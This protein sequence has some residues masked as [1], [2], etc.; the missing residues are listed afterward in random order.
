[1]K[2][3]LLLFV[4]V[5]L[6]LQMNVCAQTGFVALKEGKSEYKIASLHK[7][8]MTYISLQDFATR[9]SIKSAEH[10]VNGK[11]E[12]FSDNFSLKFG[13]YNAF[14]IVNN[15]KEQ[16]Q[17]VLQL[18]V[19]TILQ[20][21]HLF[22]PWKYLGPLCGKHLSR[23]I[24]LAVPEKV[25]IVTGKADT[26]SH[27]LLVKIEERINGT[28]VRI[29]FKKD[30][31]DVISSIKNNILTIKVTGV[32]EQWLAAPEIEQNSVI[33]SIAV[34]AGKGETVFSIKLN[35]Q[36]ATHEILKSSEQ[37]AMLTV[38]KKKFGEFSRTKDPKK[39]KW[40]FDAVV[41]DAGHGGKDFGAIGINNTIEKNIN[42]AVALKL[43][44]EIEREMPDVKVVYTRKN[45]TFVELYK[46]G[47]IANE[48]NGKLFISIHGNSVPNKV[49]GPH[50][51]E[52]YLLRP[53]RTHEAIAIAERENGVIKYEENPKRYQKLTDENF[54]LV[55][56][57]H[58][59]NMKYSE[60]FSE[61]LDK[62]LR[63]DV[64]I[65][66]KGVKQAGFYVLVGAS[67]PGILFETGYV[68]NEQDAAYLKSQGGQQ[69]IASALCKAIKSFKLYYAREINND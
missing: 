33:E 4:S 44:A 34:K 19:S 51:F 59:S 8:G 35:D 30:I 10:K 24:S 12:L 23:I 6:F 43:G 20:K 31:K 53:G 46:R 9:F 17:E 39:E 37:G 60:K 52:I 50:G 18:P 15:R 40:K 48:N 14:V 1:M 25:E 28:L 54:I 47:K 42:L 55:T 32:S 21:G 29:N 69:E 64:E 2:I 67:M 58:A 16:K 11:F 45:D 57:A 62:Q 41:I 49:A 38:H 7:N 27:N 63:E 66:S 61:L 56:M 5:L 22:V 13:N 68:T 3:L 36:Y 65:V 26:A